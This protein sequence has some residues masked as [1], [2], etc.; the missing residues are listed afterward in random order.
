MDLSRRQ[1]VRTTLSATALSMLP[2][3]FSLPRAQAF[4]GPSEYPIQ[5]MSPV[6][7][8]TFNGD[9]V[10]RTHRI[11][12]DVQ[13][14]I[15]QM[16]G[17][18]APS[19][20]HNVVVIG[21]GIAGL[22]AAYALRDQMPLLL[23]QDRAFGGNSKGEQIGNSSYSIG[24]AYVMAPRPN[25][26]TARFFNELG[27]LPY[28]RPEHGKDTTVFMQNRFAKGLWQGVTDP[29][30]R[31]S[32]EQFFAVLVEWN[33][34]I[35]AS[36]GDEPWVMELDK[37]TF[38]QWLTK[39]FGRVHPHILEYLQLYAWSSFTASIDEL[40]AYQMLEFIAAETGTLL[41]FPGGNA[42][43]AQATYAR[44]VATV[45]QARVRSRCIVVN[46]AVE[47]DSVL[48][49]Y[50]DPEGKLK[51]VRAL[52]VI[53]AAPKFVAKHVVQ[54]LPEDQ[55]KAMN[56]I[57]YRGYVVANLLLDRRV[58]SP[59]FELFHLAGEVPPTPGPMRQ[60]K[61]AFTDVV[62]G[63]W[64]QQDR[65]DRSVLSVYKAFA[66]DGDR[67]YLF[68]PA[69]HD[70]FRGQI[71]EGI[72]PLLQTLGLGPQNIQVVRM[73]RWGHSLPVAWRGLLASGVA[74]KA[75]QPVGGRLFFAN[76]DNWANPS[77]EC[78]FE[79]AITAAGHVHAVLGR[80]RLL[81]RR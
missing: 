73:T 74:E 65:T 31:A 11:L 6:S 79:E 39:T 12:W 37:L 59:S 47:Q 57:T 5:P 60:S 55:K 23:E 4:G 42:S 63:S 20:T 21:G 17:I 70:K 48:V 24:A 3:R 40:S 43:I 41:A 9:E 54:N 45:G 72:Q 14:Y 26:P 68:N 34:R 53:F 15:R 38:E 30:A 13:G 69:T 61:R 10:E 77:F 66:F 49:T 67:S 52:S 64:A 80:E 75:H 46:V 7:S 44:L 51:T 1:F 76:Q 62:F 33:R 25:T 2:F 78:A 28:A 32:F 81:R 16:G 8:Q 27:I 29:A 36:T 19:E 50:A 71:L 58:P 56:S 35:E 22:S 18:P